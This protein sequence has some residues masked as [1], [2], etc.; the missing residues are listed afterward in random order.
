VGLRRTISIVVAGLLAT[1]VAA[2]VFVGNRD[3]SSKKVRVVRGI[4]SAETQA[5]FDDPRVTEIFAKHGLDVHVDAATDRDIASGAD[6]SSY[7]FA[8]SSAGAA[9][10]VANERHTS[11]ATMPFF[12]TIACATFTNIAAVLERAGVARD[13]GGSWTLDVKRY[14]ALV[15]GHPRWI[16]LPG[17]TTYRSE[18]AVTIASGGVAQSSAAALYAAVAGYVAN[19]DTVLDS[20]EAVDSVINAVSPLFVGQGSADRS[21]DAPFEDYVSLGI[22]KTPI[23]MVDESQFV[24]RSLAND[25]SIRP[26]M[27]LIYPTPG[28]V[29]RYA[30]VALGA[31]GDSVR[32]VLADDPGI[33]QL[34]V[35]HGFR[36]PA[37]VAPTKSGKIEARL[38][39]VVDVPSYDILASL[40][41]KL[42]IAEH[43]ASSSS[44]NVHR[45][46][47][48]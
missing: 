19:D 40:V 47:R 8:L 31:A 16:D 39:N 21:W 7:D 35:A 12:T 14:I 41:A 6:L 17:N 37:P 3:S 1:A 5:L 18:A 15:K 44:V 25:G 10:E 20:P 45:S 33:T 29:S 46:G 32:R 11:A 34:A 22:E 4:V 27:V 9:A 42:D 24:A 30:L 48:P 38:G 28:V 26:D 36:V 13:D 43:L 23:A 2:T